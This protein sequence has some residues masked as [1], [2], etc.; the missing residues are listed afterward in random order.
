MITGP[1]KQYDRSKDSIINA[2]PPV[3][4]DELNGLAALQTRVDRK[5]VVAVDQAD[6]VLE[7]IAH[8]LAVLDIDGARRF[9]YDSLYFD[10]PELAAYRAAA[11]RRRRR[12][13]VRV[14]R[15]V[16][17]GRSALEI[18]TRSG[19]GETV[20]ERTDYEPEC[21]ERLNA[22]AQR[23]VDLAL[24]VDGVAHRLQPVM[25]TRYH[26]STVVDLQDRSRITLDRYLEASPSGATPQWCTLIDALV[27]ETKSTA[28]ATPLDRAL[29]AAHV[30]PVA[31]SKYAIGMAVH[32][33]DLPSNRWSRVLRNHVGKPQSAQIAVSASVVN[34]DQAKAS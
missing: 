14:R 8:R 31:I 17:A 23:F 15:Y 21:I 5:Y 30:R 9:R 7:T 32:H 3:T 27:I 10:T 22:D 25:W 28:G 16:D 26:R 4:L 13:K 34:G 29:W 18:K 12:F 33:P 24:G 2:L 1:Y 6:R 19:R 20:K 11:T